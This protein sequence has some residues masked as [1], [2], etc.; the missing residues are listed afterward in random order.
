MASNTSGNDNVAV[1]WRSLVQNTSGLV[2]NAVGIQALFSNTTGTRNSAMGNNALVANTTGGYNVPIGRS[3]SSANT[4]GSGNAALGNKALLAN[5]T[6]SFNTAIGDSAFAGGTALTNSTAVGYQT[7]ITA[8]NQMRFGNASILSI[9]GQVAWT[10]L[11]DGRFKKDVKENV[12]GLEFIM[13]LHPV[14]YHYNFDAMREDDNK[15]RLANQANI[16]YADDEIIPYASH[17]V[18]TNNN[19]KGAKAITEKRTN[20][21]ANTTTNSAVQTKMATGTPAIDPSLEA[22]YAEVKKNESIVRTGF[23]AQEVEA[24][25]KEAGYDFDGVDKPKNDQDRYGLRYAEFVVPLVKAVQEQ[26]V[27][28]DQLK[29]ENQSLK[30][31]QADVNALKERL[32]KIEKQLQSAPKY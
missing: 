22:Y 24:A 8:S 9:G 31:N 13:K 4:T 28:I 17:A 30:N 19:L 14:T 32:Q 6:G 12:K 21:V 3:S 1:G 27:M 29:A 5:T 26:Q 10:T 11:S 23:I 20:V 16:K 2:N 7:A 18:M 15:S 25:A